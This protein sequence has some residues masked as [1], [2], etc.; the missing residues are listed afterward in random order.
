M[1]ER[2]GHPTFGYFI[3]RDEYFNS[4][5]RWQETRNDVKGLARE[6]IGFENGV[7]GGV[8]NALNVF[9]SRGDKVLIH[10]PTYNGFV[11][12]VKKSL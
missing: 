10:S 9:C 7:I 2:I 5:I 8:L 12:S 4:I 1:I 6:H 3:P 11:G